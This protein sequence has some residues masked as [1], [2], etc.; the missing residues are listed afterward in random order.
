MLSYLTQGDSEA[1]VTEEPVR[2]CEQGELEG[3]DSALAGSWG[4]GRALVLSA[5]THPLPPS[6]HHTVLQRTK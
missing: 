3:A 4:W 5:P 2:I 6:P 1:L